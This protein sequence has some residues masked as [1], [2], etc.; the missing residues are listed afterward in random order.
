MTTE[1]SHVRALAPLGAPALLI[2]YELHQPTKEFDR[3]HA[4]IRKHVKTSWGS[5]VEN[6]CGAS[7][8]ILSVNESPQLVYAHLTSPDRRL[9]DDADRL[10]V[11]DLEG[12]DFAPHAGTEALPWLPDWLDRSK[13]ARLVIHERGRHPIY[14]Y[15]DDSDDVHSPTPSTWFVRT[16]QTADKLFEELTESVD[17]LPPVVDHRDTLAVSECGRVVRQGFDAPAEPTLQVTFRRHRSSPTLATVLARASDWWRNM[18]HVWIVA[19]DRPAADLVADLEGSIADV[20]SLLVA[21]FWSG[22][23]AYRPPLV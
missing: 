15:F 11:M 1:T 22:D 2:T 3:R 9:F 4:A 18:D 19:D 17:G 10:L 16:R 14:E 12:P 13:P 20:D 6:I 8:W 7:T 23:V 21:D 5:A